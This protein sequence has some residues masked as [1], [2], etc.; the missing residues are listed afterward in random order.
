MDET[1][2]NSKK[3]SFFSGFYK[4]SSKKRLEKVQDF[5]QNL[6]EDDIALLQKTG[7]ISLERVNTMIENAVGIL[8]VPLGFGVN[9]LINNKEY[10]IPMAVEEPSVIA[11]AC[12]AAK[13]TLP[14]GGFQTNSTD[15]IM[16]GQIQLLD[17][18][19]P[20]KAASI[21][22]NHK[23]EILDIANANHPSLIDHGGGAQ[24]IRTKV[25]D[26]RVG[27]MLICEIFANCSDAMGANTMSAMAEETAPFIEQLVNGRALLR[28]LSN[29]ADKRLATAKCVVSKE[30]LG[31]EAIIDNIV[32]AA[33]F[34]ESDPYRA[35]THNKGIMNGIS[36]LAL[37][38]ANDTRA[39]EAAA[40]AY[41]ARSGKY[42]SL[43][44]WTK[45]NNGNLVG[46]LELPLAFGIIGGA[47]VSNP[48]AQ[49]SLK[50]LG[51]KKAT[52]LAEIAAA[53]GLA[54]N[55]GAL[56]A[57]CTTGII[58]GHMK[59][60]AK[61]IAISAGAKGTE[62]KKISQQMLQEENIS[63][64]YAKKLLANLRLE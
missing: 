46:E 31:G 2:K 39:I 18:I 38:T 5:T 60:H 32:A 25:I 45:N 56:R 22:M 9:F 62:I 55:L 23:E 34:A 41:A 17:V 16:I 26:T 30:A 58:K 10:V 40:H 43:S 49:I 8:P 37:A 33:A 27:E 44:S 14:T 3:K 64:S 11:A 12:S 7:P 50:I 29:L 48:V 6:T 20:H 13:L 21:I 54:Q 36:S 53:V 52:E 35:V 59:L 57:L 24:D 51:I 63:F 4:L 61:N 1:T 19:S 15:P 42:S 28:I 47:T